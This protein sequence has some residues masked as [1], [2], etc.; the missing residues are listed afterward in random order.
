MIQWD[1]NYKTGIK[2]IDD[3]HKE[4]L[5][6]IGDLSDLLTNAHTGDDIYDEMVNIVDALTTYTVYHFKYEEDLF[7]KY[8]Y[9]FKESHI[10]EHA[11]LIAQISELDLSNLDEDAVTFGNKILKFLISWLFKHI[12]G[13]DFQ[14]RDMFM[15]H[16]VK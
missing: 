12:S 14:Y 4:L 10:E 11:K 7:H 5:R 9:E 16:N 6:I 13:S 1:K 15:K 2:T 3:Q 8:D